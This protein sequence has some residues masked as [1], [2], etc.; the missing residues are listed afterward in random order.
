M[1]RSVPTIDITALQRLEKFRDRCKKQHITLIFS[2]TNPYPYSVMEQA[3]FV[4]KVGAECFGANIDKALE[5]AVAWN[6]E[7]R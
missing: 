1:M 2:H 7:N 6:K 5:L 3:E 4:E